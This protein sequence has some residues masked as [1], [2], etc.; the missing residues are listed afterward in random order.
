MQKFSKIIAMAAE[1]SALPGRGNGASEQL[2][3]VVDVSLA[4][5]PA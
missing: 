1:H 2:M 3:R 5:W 4:T